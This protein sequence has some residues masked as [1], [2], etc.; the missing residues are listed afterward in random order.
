[1]NWEQIRTLRDHGVTIGSQTKSHPHMFK[2]TRE[3]II[4][5][6]QFQIK[7]Y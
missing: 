1:M 6:Y 7:I 2:L 5:E 3:K 4:E